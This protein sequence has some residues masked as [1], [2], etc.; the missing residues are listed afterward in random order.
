MKQDTFF[1][2]SYSDALNHYV[3][4]CKEG[5]G[6]KWD[7]IIL[8]AANEKQAEAYRLQIDRRRTEKCLPFGTRVCVIP[9]YRNERSGSGG[10]TLNVI[11]HIGIHEG[12]GVLPDRK[13]LVI[14]SGGD[15]KRIPQYSACGKLF[16]PVPRMLPSGS[17]SSLFDE[18]L[19]LASGIPSRTGPGMMVFPSDTEMLF[20]PLQMDLLSCD[21]AGI[22]IKAPVAEGK[23]HG[24]FLQGSRSTDSRNRNV[25]K[26]FH[27]LSESELK[28][29]GAVDDRNQVDIDTG[30]IWLGRNV[31]KTLCGLITVNDKFDQERFEEFVNPKVCLNFYAD[32]V[33][34]LSDDGTLEEFLKEAPENG[35]SEELLSCRRQIWEKLHGYSLSLVKMVPARYIHFGMT[36]ELFRL[37]VND[38]SS[39]TYLGWKKR[40]HTNA[41]QGTVLNSYVAAETKFLGRSF[42]EDSIIRDGVVAGDGIIL[43]NIEAKDCFIPDDTVLSGIKL[44]NGRY[45]CRI[46]GRE[47]NPKA[48]GNAPFLGGSLESLARAADISKKEIWEEGPAAI[49]NAMIY[50]E[51]ESMADA[52]K[53]ALTIQKIMKGEADRE[54]VSDWKKSVKHSLE[55]SFYNADV[56]WLIKWQSWIRQQIKQE[57]FYD[58][59]FAKSEMGSEIDCLCRGSNIQ[60]IKESVQA[61]ASRAETEN[62]PNNMRLY[63]AAADTCK[64]YLK[65][66]V[67]KA[68]IYENQAY[69][70]VKECI[71]KEIFSRFRLDYHAV[72]MKQDKVDVE[73][74]VR[75]NFCGSPSDAAPYCLE[76]GGT[77]IN[78]ALLLKGKKPVRVTIEKTREGITF[79]SVDQKDC[80]Y[81]AD[82]HDIQKRTYPSDPFALHKSALTATGLIPLE[83]DY[84]M[85]EFCS[86]IGGGF[87]LTTD[88]DV[89]KGSGL[90]TSSILAAAVI[91]AV[92][93][94]FGNNPSDEMVYAQ[95]F[96]AEQLMNTGGGWQDQAGGL[97][98]GIKYLTAAP[99]I[100]QKIN[101]DVLNLPQK[102]MDELNSRFVLIFSGQRRLARNVLREEMNQCIRNNRSVLEVIK[103]IQEYCAVMRHYLLKGEITEFAKYIT[104]QFELV[105][106][107]DSGVSNTCIEY[108]FD[109]IDDLADGKAVCGAGGGGFLQVILKEGVRIEHLKERIAEKFTDCGVEVWECKLI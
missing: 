74:P 42:L 85:E 16:A 92:H 50:P 93:L 94:M 35:I 23:E 25:A 47:D 55:S 10:A 60:E 99:G 26:F 38:I 43:S 8:T 33:Y 109:A 34:P 95:V 54:E 37:F 51:R 24:V 101:V 7:W 65:D 67:Q 98:G 61:M 105:K 90:G 68:D 83:E 64:K 6:E 44:K 86:A 88:V 1:K 22:S 103:E 77:M 21:A 108:I 102:T 71:Y 4:S 13:I 96:L 19:I 27:K 52:V 66:Y 73:L 5:K 15:S 91:K 2:Q 62:F 56:P 12:F 104:R 46:Y 41:T 76:Y 106:T 28:K 78:G 72:S 30:C 53:S 48:S 3:Y 80:V 39:Y 57:I 63:L 82:M 70:A 9:D 81:F 84:N 75:V 69:E 18:L 14:H 17:V 20:N 31:L 59:L 107:I 89:P 11:R 49:W 36:N 58:A 32:F 97:T 100:Y 45:V 29:S 40:I 87:C 79:K